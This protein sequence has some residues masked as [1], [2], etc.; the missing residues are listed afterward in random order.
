[1]AWSRVIMKSCIIVGLA[2]V[3]GAECTSAPGG[4]EHV[5]RE[6]RRQ[7]AVAEEVQLAG[8]R[9]QLRVGRERRR[10]AAAEVVAADA[11]RAR[12]SARRAGGPPRAPR[13]ARRG[14]GRGCS[15]RSPSGPSSSPGRSRRAAARTS[16]CARSGCGTTRPR[17]PSRR[18]PWTMPSP[19]NQCAGRAAVPGSTRCA[20]S[21]PTSAGGMAPVTARSSVGQLLV[22]RSVVAGQEPWRRPRR[23]SMLPHSPVDCCHPR[24]CSSRQSATASWPARDARRCASRSPRPSRRC[25]RRDSTSQPASKP[26]SSAHASAAT[27]GAVVRLWTSVH[28]G[29]ERAPAP[30][31]APPARPAAPAA[32]RRRPSGRRRAGTRRSADRPQWRRAGQAH[33]ERRRRGAARGD[34]LGGPVVVDDVV[35]ERDV[36]ADARR[37]SPDP[38]AVRIS[39]TRSRDRRRHEQ[40]DRPAAAAPISRSSSGGSAACRRRLSDDDSSTPPQRLD[41]RRRPDVVVVARH[42]DALDADGAGDDQAL[43]QDLGGVAATAVGR[44]STA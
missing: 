13:S 11:C 31:A 43:A 30:S 44:R 29:A 27:V 39:S 9:A 5:V 34:E 4:V 14:R 10:Q 32:R 16:S 6:V 38:S 28:V 3:I 33:R 8:L 18:T 42:E 26:S 37:T 21:G 19:K 25:R 24:Q 2:T 41:H 35:D 17:P 40:H 1:M 36:G 12:A 22:H 20:G 15:P 23:S 7:H